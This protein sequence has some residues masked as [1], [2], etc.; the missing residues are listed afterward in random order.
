MSDQIAEFNTTLDQII[1]KSIEIDQNRHPDLKNLKHCIL[2]KGQRSHKIAKYWTIIDR[3]TGNIH[4]HVLT[5]ETLDHTKKHGWRLKKENSITL[6][7]EEGDDIQK[8]FDF[9]ATSSHIEGNAT[10]TIIRQDDDRISRILDAITATGQRQ[11]LINQILAWIDDEPSAITGLVEFS[12]AQPT[13][14]KSL[15]AALN[16]GYYSKTLDEFRQLI[17]ANT[18]ERKYQKFLEANFW[19]FGSEFCEL[20]KIRD[21]MANKQL[22]FPLRR[23]VDEYLEII[24]IK[25][26]IPDHLFVGSHLSPRAE[27]SEATAQAETYLDLLD[28]ESDRIWRQYEIRA[29]KVRAKVIIGRDGD[30]EQIEA[31]RRYNA[32]RSRVETITFDQLLRVGQRILSVLASENIHISVPNLDDIPF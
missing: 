14:S 32:N 13:R 16:Y 25:R 12:A 2:R 9:I 17:E 5:L 22:D 15:I 24:E 23:T 28:R 20:V 3:N 1:A 7:N 27:L 8:L 4:H 6:T 30:K 26:P 19:I 18:Q 10:Y 31:L 21:M 11:E 29:D